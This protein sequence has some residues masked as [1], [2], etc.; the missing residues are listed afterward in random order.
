MSVRYTRSAVV[1]LAHESGLR[2]YTYA[3]LAYIA[4][5][6]EKLSVG[7]AMQVHDLLRDRE[8]MTA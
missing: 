6:A 5:H 2:G 7:S 8:E 1:A 3:E 4:A